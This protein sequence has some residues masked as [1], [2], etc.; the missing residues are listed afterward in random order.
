MCRESNTEERIRRSREVVR[1]CI[2]RR[3]EGHIVS[4]QSVINA[5]SDLMPELGDHLA[6]LRVIENA[7][8]QIDS[9]RLST[10]SGFCIRCPN[11]HTPVEI[12]HDEQLS[13]VECSSCGSVFGLLGDDVVSIDGVE[14]GVVGGKRTFGDVFEV[15]V[16][17]NRRV[18]G[19]VHIT[20][21][22]GG[23]TGITLWKGLCNHGLARE[24]CR[25][26]EDQ[27][28]PLPN[29]EVHGWLPSGCPIVRS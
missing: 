17:Y 10:P 26:Q 23:D 7:Q 27:G 15:F 9:Y 11:C 2:R 18:I 12:D 21:I 22:L 14:A 29:S 16:E 5:N 6:G 28:N 8:R 24:Q 4:D 3:A 25:G 20:R 13:R 19:D 1:D